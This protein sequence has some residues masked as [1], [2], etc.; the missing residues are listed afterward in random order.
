LLTEYSAIIGYVS[1]VKR[2]VHKALDHGDRNVQVTLYEELRSFFGRTATWA[3]QGDEPKLRELQ[4]PLAA[5][6][7]EMFSREIDVSAEAIRRERAE[8]AVSYITLCKHTGLEI[9]GELRG[10]LKAWREVE[11]SG[12]V[13]QVLDRALAKTYAMKHELSTSRP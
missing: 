13:Q 2:L 1:D 3:S 11:R 12:P 7:G 10:L 6:A 5:L 4:E 9:N 8:A